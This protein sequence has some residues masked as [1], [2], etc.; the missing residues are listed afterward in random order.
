[1]LGL[2]LNCGKLSYP[3]KR[4][5]QTFLGRK[6]ELDGAI[7]ILGTKRGVSE[8]FSKQCVKLSLNECIS[9]AVTPIINGVVYN[10]NLSNI[11]TDDP[12]SSAEIRVM[13]KH[14]SFQSSSLS[15]ENLVLDNRNSKN[16]VQAVKIRSKGD[17]PSAFPVLALVKR[18]IH[19]PLVNHG[20]Y[21]RLQPF[22]VENL[23]YHKRVTESTAERRNNRPLLVVQTQAKL[24]EIDSMSTGNR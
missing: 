4:S 10:V 3:S 15:S 7:F 16:F 11:R 9:F 20:V 5:A 24:P 21:L 2:L 8:L 6:E 23:V 17:I 19:T 13:A 22:N 14:Y 18:W 1:M 12:S